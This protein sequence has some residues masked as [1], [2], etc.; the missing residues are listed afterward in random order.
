MKLSQLMKRVKTTSICE[1]YEI[2]FVTDDFEKIEENCLF[3]C[4]NGHKTDAHIFAHEAIK[5]GAAAVVVERDMDIDKQIIVK[6]TRE[7]YA[8]LCSAFYGNPA[9]KLKIIGITGT[10]GKTS[11]SFLLSE[12]I[13]LSGHKTGLIGTVVDII[14]DKEID[15]KLTTPD[16]AELFKYLSEMVENGCEYCVM[17]TSSQALDQKRLSG[18]KF[19][20]G[21]FTNLT[22]DHL[23]Y[24]KTMENY[25]NAKRTLF[26]NCKKAV[27][28]LDDKNGLKICEDLDI[29]TVTYST[30][31]DHADY[32]AKNV[33]YYDD[34]VKYELVGMGVIGRVKL[35]IPGKFSVY[36][37]MAAA[38][39]ALE[40]GTDM[41][42]ITEI[43]SKTKGVKGRMET[44]ETNK[45]YTVIID[46]AHTPDGLENLLTSLRRV[47][48]GRIITVFGC[49]GDR[50][51]SKRPEMGRI[52]GNNS[53]ITIVTSDNPRSENPEEIINDILEGMNDIKSKKYTI[54][55]RTEAI[56]K[57]LSVARTGDVVVL[58]GK[59]H[60][61]YQI[62]KSGK[63]HYDEREIVNEI[64][65][66]KR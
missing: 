44:V 10:N 43:L 59:G 31:N 28:N 61:T 26:S 15:S 65:K 38:V 66:N 41:S 18:I 7:A 27:V 37:S 22:V 24:H 51:K 21:V 8:F 34:S 48:N 46:Y 19:E 35:H 5:K 42:K 57:A 6:D 1:D 50:D 54:C 29:E 2:S 63:I 9:D 30:K 56:E 60:E 23:D 11:T 13:K 47:Y 20:I 64:L 17:E 53:D 55:D 25:F 52:A 58:A 62:L 36:N 40:L 3:V 14:G 32:T 4:I 16:S 33:E 39:T 12:L 49:G 45:D